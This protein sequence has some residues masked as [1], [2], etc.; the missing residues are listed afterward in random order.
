VFY[1]SSLDILMIDNF[2][3]ESLGCVQAQMG[4]ITQVRKIDTSLSLSTR[5]FVKGIQ[6]TG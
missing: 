3:N 1:V 4:S 6:V 2:L 5:A